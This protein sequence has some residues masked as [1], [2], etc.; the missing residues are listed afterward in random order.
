MAEGDPEE[1]AFERKYSTPGMAE[2]SPPPVAR[3]VVYINVSGGIAEAT[4]MRG[5]V[6]V[7]L[8]DWDNYNEGIDDSLTYD[9]LLQ[10]RE[11]LATLP[12]SRYKEQLLA[13]ADELIEE[14]ATEYG[15]PD[16]D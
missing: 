2:A 11:D 5:D 3:A 10:D 9:R 7:V 4:V 16:D 12:D 15:E 6:D 14:Y 8:V 13:D 1:L